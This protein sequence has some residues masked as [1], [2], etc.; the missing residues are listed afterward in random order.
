MQPRWRKVLSDL[1]SNKTRTIL[2]GLSIGIG[3]FALGMVAEHWSGPATGAIGARASKH[4]AAAGRRA[5]HCI[6]QRTTDTALLQ[7]MQTFDRRPARAGHPVPEH[8][9]VLPC[10]QD[11]SA[12]PHDGLGSKLCGHFPR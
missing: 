8:P 12:R 2:V 7:L 11:H 1:W 9:G 3:V 6:D 10:L 5:P 4:L